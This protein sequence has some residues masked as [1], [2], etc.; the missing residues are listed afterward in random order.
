MPCHGW[1]SDM[2]P[3]LKADMTPKDIL[4]EYW[5]YDSF[6]LKQ[7]EIV[8][9]ALEDRDVLAILPTGG[10]KSIC[11]QVPALMREGIAIVITPLIALM[12]D[13]VQNIN[14]RGIK[15][16]GGNAGMGRR[17]VELALNNAA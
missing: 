14:D 4:S 11:F 9:V 15:S 2:K 1:N 6:R 16:L 3:E 12:K 5:G 8:N 13:Q 17:A 7:E 10:G